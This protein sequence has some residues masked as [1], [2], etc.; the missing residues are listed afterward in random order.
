MDKKQFYKK[1]DELTEEWYIDAT[2]PIKGTWATKIHPK[3]IARRKTNQKG[4]ENEINETSG[5]V[6]VIRWAKREQ[7]CLECCKMVCGKVEEIN[8]EKGRVKCSCGMKYPVINLVLKQ[9]AE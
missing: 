8:L 3:G 6:Q 1:I 2:P 5:E 7:M 4:E 9:M